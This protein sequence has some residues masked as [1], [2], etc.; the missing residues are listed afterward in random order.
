MISMDGV[1]G[2]FEAVL[3]RGITGL[4][5]VHGADNTLCDRRKSAIPLG[6]SSLRAQDDT[7]DEQSMRADTDFDLDASYSAA[8][9]DYIKAREEWDALACAEPR[10]EAGPWDML[11]AY[12]E[13][14]PAHYEAMVEKY[15]LAG[16]L[17]LECLNEGGE[18]AGHRSSGKT[19]AA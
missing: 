7:Y 6:E 1:E 13:N 8:L 17:Y 14:L 3:R 5:Y 19:G 9:A 18:E 11:R 16:N 2:S 12:W 4:T 15:I 10:N